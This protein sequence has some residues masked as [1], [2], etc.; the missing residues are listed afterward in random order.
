MEALGI[1][2]ELNQIM[3][4]CRYFKGSEE[5]KRYK[6]WHGKLADYFETKCNNTARKI[7]VQSQC[8]TSVFFY[9]SRSGVLVLM[10]RQMSVCHN[11]VLTGAAYTS[12]SH[13]GSGKTWSI[14]HWLDSVWNDVWWWIQHETVAILE[15]GIPYP[16]L[17]NLLVLK[18][19]IIKLNNS[20]FI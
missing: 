10:T 13:R 12:D 7:E 4:N 8:F 19:S 2:V 5:K 17:R 18:H 16:F 1:V 15:K 14:P 20:F 11:F 3:S 9:Y 6:W